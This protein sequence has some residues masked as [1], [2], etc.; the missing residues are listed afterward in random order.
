[1]FTASQ[2][3][4]VHTKW[5]Y[6]SQDQLQYPTE[7]IFTAQN[8]SVQVRIVMDVQQTDPLVTGPPPGLVIYEQTSHFSGTIIIQGQSSSEITF[9][10]DGFKEYTGVT[11]ATQ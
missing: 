3:S 4:I 10:G 9:A 8:G 7:T 11:S 5:A 1:V 2:Y 6:D